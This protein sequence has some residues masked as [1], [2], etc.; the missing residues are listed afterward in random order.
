MEVW[1]SVFFKVID[2]SM[3]T[4]YQKDE[5]RLSMNFVRI[6]SLI[7]KLIPISEITMYGMGNMQEEKNSVCLISNKSRKHFKPCFLVNQIKWTERRTLF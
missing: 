1:L 2:I 3:A 5:N 7:E 4:I 6:R